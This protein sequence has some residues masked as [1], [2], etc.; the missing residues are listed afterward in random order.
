MHYSI[1]MCTYCGSNDAQTCL[2]NNSNHLIART[3]G[4]NTIGVFI[5]LHKHFWLIIENK[6]DQGFN[7]ALRV[8]AIVENR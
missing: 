2:S 4:D 6:Y 8:T 3:W 5:E 1:S 7:R